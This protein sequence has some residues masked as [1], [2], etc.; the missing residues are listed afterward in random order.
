M[1]F[2]SH[3][4]NNRIS[5]HPSVGMATRNFLSLGSGEVIARV[6]AAVATIYIARTLGVVSYGIVGFIAAMMLYFSA[7]IDMGIQYFGPHEIAKNDQRH[8]E[9]LIPSILITLC[10]EL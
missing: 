10:I 2:L 6:I 5:Q 9:N 7:I 1:S 8:A 3:T 4:E